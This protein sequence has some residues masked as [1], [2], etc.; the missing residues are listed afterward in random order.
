MLKKLFKDESHKNILDYIEKIIVTLLSWLMQLGVFIM[1]F[2]AILI[3][4]DFYYNFFIN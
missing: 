4:L 1:S 3:V 2:Q